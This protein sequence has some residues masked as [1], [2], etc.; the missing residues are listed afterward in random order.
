MYVSLSVYMYRYI[1]NV[2][3]RIMFTPAHIHMHIRIHTQVVGVW[4]ECMIK[5]QTSLLYSLAVMLSQI[6]DE[7]YFKAVYL[8]INAPHLDRCAPGGC[9]SVWTHVQ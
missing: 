8:P 4:R 9:V 3:T 6:F 1:C 5:A 2:Y 7:L